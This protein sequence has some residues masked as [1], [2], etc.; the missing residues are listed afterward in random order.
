[1]KTLKLAAASILAAAAL[2]QGAHA[3]TAIYLSG[4]PATRAIWNQAIYNTLANLTGGGGA[5]IVKTWSGSSGYNL[6]NQIILTGGTIGGQA[7][8]IYGSWTGSTGGNQ[9]VANTPPATISSFQV[10]FLDLAHLSVGLGQGGNTLGTTN[11][12]YPHANLS[13]TFQ[14][15]VPFNGTTNVTSP[16]TSYVTLNEATTASPAVTGYEFVTNNGAPSGLNNITTNL[17]RELF[18]NAGTPLALFTGSSANKS[19]IVYPVGRDISSGARYILLAETG[20]G[21]ANS[22]SLVQFEPAISSGTISDIVDNP[23]PGGTLNLISFDDGNGGYSSFTPVLSVLEATSIPSI[24]YVVSY[25]TDS[26][27]ATAV[28]DGARALSWNGVPYSVAGIQQ[29]QY[30]YWSFLHVFYNNTNSYIQNNFPLSKTFADDLASDLSTDTGTGAILSSSLV[31]Q[32]LGG[33]GA[34]ITPKYY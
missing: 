11:K 5:S 31:V 27:A 22:D 15:T 8:T 13:D 19:T 3:Q 24:G 23:A 9:S 17:A 25:V 29:G 7:V 26:D 21:T 34:T 33:D 6:A 32:R 30:T 1:M 2:L 18:T 14:A 16:S 4:A 28:A 20:I 12:Q 10:A